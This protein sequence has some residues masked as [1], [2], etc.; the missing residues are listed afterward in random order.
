MRIL[1]EA[2]VFSLLLFLPV[3]ILFLGKFAALTLTLKIVVVSLALIALLMLPVYAHI[4]FQVKVTADELITYSVLG[5]HSCKLSQLKGLKRRSNWGWIRYVVEFE[6][7]ELS[8]PVWMQDCEKLVAALRAALPAGCGGAQNPFRI[9]KQDPIA[10][11]YQFGQALVSLVFAGIVWFFAISTHQSGHHNTADMALLYTFAL[12]VSAVLIWRAYMVALM[13]RSVE[14]KP[15]QL[16]LVTVFSRVELPW[17]SVKAL[18]ESFALLP[19][20]FVINTAKGRFLIGHGMDEADELESS[21]KANLARVTAP[22]EISFAPAEPLLELAGP[23]ELE[24][25]AQ[26]EIESQ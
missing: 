8:F 26:I 25:S 14:V 7:G 12:V 3:V 4:T 10:L 22:A 18:T 19:E 17:K 23:A 1:A 21:L 20:G 16:L 2:T 15:D 6:G 13:P 24:Q 5:K 11:A 9:F